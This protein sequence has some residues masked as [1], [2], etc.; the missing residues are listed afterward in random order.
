LKDDILALCLKLE[1]SYY[2]VINNILKDFFLVSF[3]LEAFFNIIFL[4][5]EIYIFEFPYFFFCLKIHTFYCK[6]FLTS[7][8][9]FFFFFL[10]STFVSDV[11]LKP[12]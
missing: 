3:L 9:M 2:R 4:H 11:D 7:H 6:W 10:N 8:F 12:S 5:G 1:I